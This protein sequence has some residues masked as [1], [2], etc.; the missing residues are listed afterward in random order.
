MPKQTHSTT[1]NLTATQSD[2]AIYLPAISGAYTS[3]LAAKKRKPSTMD[4]I[5]DLN[6][7]RNDK[8]AV[9]TYD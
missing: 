8:D 9:Y 1:N 3:T 5:D 6:F 4:T 2:Y 7:F